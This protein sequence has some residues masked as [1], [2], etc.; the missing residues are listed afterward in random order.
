[1]RRKFF[2]SKFIMFLILTFVPICIFGFILVF[3]INHQVKKDAEAK[4]MATTELMS[5]YMEE[6]TNSLEFYRVIVN[7]DAKLNL[8]LVQVLGNG[9]LTPLLLQNLQQSMQSIYYSQS[10][11]PYIQSLYITMK[12]SPYFING[13]GRER[14]SEAVDKTW[15]DGLEDSAENTF[16]KVRDIKKNKFDA[17][18]V[19][20]VTVYY[21]LKYN[22]IMA[23]NIKQ[24][25]FN[26]WLE[27]IADYEGQA[28]MILDQNDQLLFSNVNADRIATE[29]LH[30]AE[31]GSKLSPVSLHL[32]NGYM[33][34]VGVFPGSY[35]LKYVSMIPQAE[36]FKLSNLIL[37]LTLG[38]SLLSIVLSSLLAYIFTVRDYK[39]I[40]QIIDFFEKAEKEN[41]EP[42]VPNPASQS[43]YF[44]ILNNIINLFVS[45]TYLN[46]QL[47]AKKY[48]LSTAQLS[49]LQYQLNPHF[50]F[51]TLQSIDL[52]ILKQQKGPTSA[53]KM[54]AALSQLLRY[55]LDDPMKP[56]TVQEE[57]SITKSYIELQQYKHGTYFQVTWEYSEEVLDCPMLRLLL[58][59]LIEN[60]LTHSGKTPPEKL[61]IKIKIHRIGRHL[62]FVILDNGYGITS[63]RLTQ[64]R[65]ELT[66][67]QVDSSGMHIGL[68]N[69]SQRIHLAYEEG[70]MKLYSKEGMGTMIMFFISL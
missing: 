19:R 10:S 46:V 47:E 58:Q 33:K 28:L 41:F 54:I 11:K 16:F 3:N 63:G 45:K 66:D 5:Q 1:M 6:L 67:T 13:V 27:S 23:I 38:A 31:N 26:Q 49:A 57:I 9:E 48:A 34:N 55:S 36:V 24:D 2:Y 29:F 37:W 20:T 35:H 39:E 21:Q 18:T 62:Q 25:Y 69:I 68:K 52:E 50:L 64:L 60:A 61:W 43:P 7:S 14:F 53:N 15:A 4:T 30:N 65:A 51:N 56:V 42:L 22:E 32:E 17:N 12:D 8:A 44:H 40:F 59:P 70:D